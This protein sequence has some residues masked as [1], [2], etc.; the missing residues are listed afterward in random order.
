M[1]SGCTV[2]L[3]SKKTKVGSSDQEAFAS[4]GKNTV[5]VLILCQTSKDVLTAISSGMD[6]TQDPGCF[7]VT[8]DVFSVR[9]KKL[10]QRFSSHE[11]R[12]YLLTK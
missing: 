11:L 10:L 7:F 6:I 2:L 8:T 5:A 9:I 1:F 12:I 4:T 3:D